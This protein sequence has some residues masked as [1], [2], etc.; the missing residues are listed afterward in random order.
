VV[1]RQ[2]GLVAGLHLQHGFVPA[3]A[4]DF[5]QCEL[6][7]VACNS[8]PAVG[9]MDGDV[10]DGPGVGF[11]MAGSQADVG[12]DLAGVGPHESLEP[13]HLVAG[14][15]PAIGVPAQP[16]Q[17][18]HG[19][20]ALQHLAARVVEGI[21]EAQFDQVGDFEQVGGELGGTGAEGGEATRIE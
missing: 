20:C 8:A 17:A 6:G 11:A 4:A 16:A 5:F 21:E 2:G 9:G 18:G 19:P 15:H 7:E 3:L 13:I 12:D 14:A 1:E 10:G